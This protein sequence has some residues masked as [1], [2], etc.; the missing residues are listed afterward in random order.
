VGLLG[1][2][3]DFR[4]RRDKKTAL[5]SLLPA[6]PY[7]PF[8]VQVKGGLPPA[9]PSTAQHTACSL[10]LLEVREGEPEDLELSGDDSALAAAGTGHPANQLTS[11]LEPP[12]L[13]GLRPI[14]H[15][16]HPAHR[17]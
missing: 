17:H 3:N 6:F 14:P 13:L 5:G 4:S 8:S 11:G 10:T 1:D 15:A 12:R 16:L 2:R 9:K 7:P